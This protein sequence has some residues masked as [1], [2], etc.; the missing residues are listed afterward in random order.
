M[1]V[2]ACTVNCDKTHWFWVNEGI[3]VYVSLRMHN[4]TILK[5]DNSHIFFILEFN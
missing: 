5:Q 4:T 2:S 1:K 3:G